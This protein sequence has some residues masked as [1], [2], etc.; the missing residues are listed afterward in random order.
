[1]NTLLTVSVFL[2]FLGTVKYL[3]FLGMKSRTTGLLATGMIAAGFVAETV[4]LGQR[5]ALTGHGPYMNAFE[6]LLFGAWAVFG[7]FLL[8]E[9]YFRIKPLGAFMAPVG[10]LLSLLAVVFSGQ[11]GEG[12]VPVHSY[13]LTLHRALSFVAFG[14]FSLTFAA[15]IMY[16]ILERQLKAKHFGAWYHRLPSLSQLDDA[17]RIGLYVGVPI[18]TISMVAASFWSAQHY[19]VYLKSDLSTI[20]LLLAWGIFTVCLAGRV[21][22]GWRGKRAAVMGVTGFAVVLVSLVKHLG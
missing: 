9:L 3:L 20:L 22:R 16:L 8:A 1:M 7:V 2:Y 17:N 11:A 12:A 18:I 15:G 10:F 19:G 13:W 21:S 14:A 5:S 4:G 6:Q